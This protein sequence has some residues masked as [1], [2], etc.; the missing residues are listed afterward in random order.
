[1]NIIGIDP[2]KSGAIAI[3]NGGIDRIVK[4][5]LNVINM[6]DEIRKIKDK[7]NSLTIH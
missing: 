5:P 2:G 4:C 3:W 7:R 1:M 6:A